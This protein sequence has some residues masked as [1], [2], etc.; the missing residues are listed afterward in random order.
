MNIFLIFL[1]K[2]N[3]FW[4]PHEV[5]TQICSMREDR[6]IC[7]GTFCPD[8]KLALKIKDDL[9]KQLAVCSVSK[10]W[11]IIIFRYRNKRV[12]RLFNSH[13]LL[14]NQESEKNIW[15][16][17]NVQHAHNKQITHLNICT[18]AILQIHMC[19]GDSYPNAFKFCEKKRKI[20]HIFDYILKNIYIIS[21]LTKDVTVLGM[22][23]FPFFL[24]K[25]N[26]FE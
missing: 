8:W 24:F 1:L 6:K 23:I 4:L 22:N 15:G 20:N 3:V 19:V 11:Q 5:T 2:L 10:T 13:R 12:A 25:R 21:M 17:L 18:H 14:R 26:F 9:H 7:S 16:N